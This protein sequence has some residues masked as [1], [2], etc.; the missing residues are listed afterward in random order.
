MNQ[1]NPR[2]LEQLKQMLKNYNMF[3][4][5]LNDSSLPHTE[6]QII[7]A[8]LVMLKQFMFSKTRDIKRQ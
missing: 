2:D 5:K 4:A 1:S 7:E 6:R 8:A 3:E